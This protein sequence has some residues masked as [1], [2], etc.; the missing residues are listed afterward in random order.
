MRLISLNPDYDDIIVKEDDT[1]EV[2]GTVIT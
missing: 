2:I 1:I